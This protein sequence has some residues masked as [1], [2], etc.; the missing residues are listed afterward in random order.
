MITYKYVCIWRHTSVSIYN[1]TIMF[2]AL[3]ALDT[4]ENVLNENLATW[5]KILLISLSF[6]ALSIVVSFLHIS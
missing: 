2:W 5:W 1:L 4:H 6:I 3:G